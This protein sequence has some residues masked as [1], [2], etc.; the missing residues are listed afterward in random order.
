MS[1]AAV[2]YS[3]LATLEIGF[4]SEHVLS[5]ALNRPKALNSF[6]PALWRDFKAAFDRA[7][8]DSRVRC[9]VL[10]ANGRA[11][12]AGLDLS[13]S[14]L[15]DVRAPG[16]PARKAFTLRRGILELQK[17]FDAMEECNK[18]VICV[19][20]GAVIGAGVDLASAADIRY[21]SEDCF[22]SIKEVDVALA[23][24]VGTL[25]RFPR[26]IGN[27]SV[28]VCEFNAAGGDTLL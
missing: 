25:A 19:L 26:L 16:E 5:I 12:T 8:S 27:D 14:I 10:S 11:F 23:A 9:I 13:E 3:D 7:A 20:H 22:M 1:P 15:D 21:A 2:N 18:P 4:Q 17:S 6:N 24:D 28:W